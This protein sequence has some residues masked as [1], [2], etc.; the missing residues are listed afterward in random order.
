MSWKAQF[1][2]GLETYRVPLF[3]LTVATFTILVARLFVDG[4]AAFSLALL[5]F[6]IGAAVLLAAGVSAAYTIVRVA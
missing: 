5:A 4:M 6:V 2:S 1:E 3:L